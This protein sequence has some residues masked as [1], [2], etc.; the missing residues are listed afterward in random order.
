MNK[1]ILVTGLSISS[2]IAGIAFE[3]QRTISTLQRC[4]DPYILY[5]S[6]KLQKVCTNQQ[7][8]IVT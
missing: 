8:K 2:F 5:T 4:D 1:K 7:E 6:D 3:K